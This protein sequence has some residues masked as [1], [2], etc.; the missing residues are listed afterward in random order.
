MS[1]PLG[2]QLSE[3]VRDAVTPPL[4]GGRGAFFGK[5]G[6]DEAAIEVKC[7]DLW[8]AWGLTVDTVEAGA[9]GAEGRRDP[10]EGR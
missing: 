5:A 4:V 1:L 2:M 10:A 7:G 6:L 8:D 3:L 9:F